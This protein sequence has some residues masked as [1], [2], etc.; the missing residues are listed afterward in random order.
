[1]TSVVVREL[2]DFEAEVLL[3]GHSLD[4]L[5]PNMLK[6]P[7][8]YEISDEDLDSVASHDSSQEEEEEEE[9]EEDDWFPSLLKESMIEFLEDDTRMLDGHET[10][11]DSEEDA[12]I[13]EREEKQPRTSREQFIQNDETFNY[14]SAATQPTSNNY[15]TM[16]QFL[17][18]LTR[19]TKIETRHEES[20]S[21]PP[22]IRRSS[23]FTSFDSTCSIDW[24]REKRT[25][26]FKD[27]YVS[28]PSLDNVDEDDACI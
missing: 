1:M 3:S 19:K 4:T 10:L 26:S 12:E 18:D 21:S 20:S 6:S 11:L 7:P 22:L 5:T 15:N 24:H 16:F 9:E 2:D 27:D 28:F 23:S 25:W 17:V 8:F 14:H 13:V